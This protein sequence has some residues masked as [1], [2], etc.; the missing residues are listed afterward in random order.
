M[1]CLSWWSMPKNKKPA[2]S[3][4]KWLL[5]SVA[6]ALT[7]AVG[8]FA[9]TM[10]SAD[11]L[12]TVAIKGQKVTLDP[13]HFFGAAPEA[14]EVAAKQP[15]L[16]TQ[17][18]CYCGCDRELGHQCLLDCYRNDH[19][20]HCPVCIGEAVEGAKLADEALPIDQIRRV[21]R[22]HYAQGN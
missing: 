13:N 9:W 17:L 16:L 3:K 1:M 20:A 2:N 4:T 10:H 21:L 19:A 5:A 7:L 15:A 14:Y 8:V 11:Q 12:A 18:H 22:D 6:G